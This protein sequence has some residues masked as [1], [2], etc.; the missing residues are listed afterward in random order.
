[1]KAVERKQELEKKRNYLLEEIDSLSDKIGELLKKNPN[2]N[3]SRSSGELENE[4]KR[5][6]NDLKRK[7]TTRNNLNIQKITLKN[8]LNKLNSDKTKLSSNPE[9]LN[10]SSENQAMKYVEFLNELSRDQIEKEKITFIKNI[11]KSSNNIQ[12]NII[13]SGTAN[14]LVVLYSKID[15]KDLSIDF[16]DIDG[17][18]NPGHGAQL[19]LSKLSII[20]SVLNLSNEKVDEVFPFIVDAPTSDFDDTIYEPYIKSLSSN[21]VQ[22]IVILKDI[23]NEIDSYKNKNYVDTL[24]KIEKNLLNDGKSTM[25]N[26]YTTINKIK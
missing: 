9:E 22:S 14:N 26:S 4:F 15:P 20:S 10:S 24:Y 16:I 8:K 19:T 3:D 21:L 11:E 1:M 23:N 13:K 6:E 25:E 12:E 17:N 5:V 18:P 7:E 2:L